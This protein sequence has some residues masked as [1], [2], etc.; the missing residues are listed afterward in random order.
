MLTST[1]TST[2]TIIKLQYFYDS[3]TSKKLTN[4]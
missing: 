3:Y 4:Q 1:I 2:I